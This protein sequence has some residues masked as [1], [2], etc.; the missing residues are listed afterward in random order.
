MPHFIY[1]ITPTRPDMP[2]N[3]S[4]AE[5]ASVGRHFAHLK[6]AVQEGR[7]LMAGR[8]ADADTFGIVIFEA[9]DEFA[10]Q[11]FAASDPGVSEGVFRLVE[12]RPFSVALWNQEFQP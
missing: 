10:A 8:T 7:A 3:P 5:K 9:E 4:E 1:R 11:N 6:S 12:V 2:N